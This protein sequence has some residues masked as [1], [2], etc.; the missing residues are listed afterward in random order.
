LAAR[1]VICCGVTLVPAVARAA[2]SCE[3]LKSTALPNTTIVAAEV[4]APGAFSASGARSGA[5]VPADFQKLP[6]FCRVHGVAAPSAD[7]HIE[8]EVWLPATGWNGKYEGVGNGGF[9]GSLNLSNMAA[10]LSAGYATATTDTGHKA[11]G[12]DAQ[13]ARGHPEKIV[14][15]GYRAIHETAVI[16]KE[17]IRAFY[18]EPAKRSYFS[19]C[20]NGGRQALM[21]AQRFPDD[22]DGIIAG[23]PAANFTRIGALFVS[24][25]LAGADPAGFV[26]PAK[27]AAVEA[28]VNAACDAR[29]G[30]KDGIVSQ[31]ATCAFDPA[32]L[33]CGADASN[34][35]LT[36]SQVATVKGLYAGLRAS[37]PQPLYP[38]FAPGG[39]SGPGGWSLWISGSAPAQSLE[40]AFGTQ[41]FT[42]MV[43]P[44]RPFD[45]RTFTIG[46]DVKAADDAVGRM[47]NAIDPDLSAFEKR[48]G[49]LIL[50][51]GWSDAALPPAATIDYYRS[52]VAKLGSKRTESFVR[53]YMVPGMQHCGG[54]PGP[55]SFGALPGL[56]PLD[57]DPARN[58]SAALEGW[59]E[60]GTPPSAII[61]TKYKDR[62]PA[63]GISYTRPLC[64]YP[65]VAR[66]KGSGSPEDAANFICAS[67]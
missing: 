31:P 17:L 48:G 12:T 46:R 5:P 47:L 66:Y 65:Q 6:A 40:Y 7:S 26:P 24:N 28:A 22:Y 20:S 54:G 57:A 60:Q 16:A 55:D 15:Y 33:L 44:D 58:M 21:E 13:W 38:G 43:Y 39:E 34:S 67:P 25:L 8:F 61:A 59:V 50:Y 51:H 2:T 62:T 10:A 41:F 11:D 18:G 63:S 32:T 23:A 19:S 52:V 45:Y 9:A 35:C 29:D 49:K 3:A 53:T 14:D 64:P 1:A 36:A 4:V 56:P 27:Y 37:G 42:N 30:V